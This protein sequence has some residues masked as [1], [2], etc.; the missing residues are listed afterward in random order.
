[1]LVDEIVRA[2]KRQVG[3]ETGSLI[4]TEDVF[5]WINEAQIQI[6][7]KTGDTTT[8]SPAIPVAVGDGRYSIP[9]DFLKVLH[10]ELDGRRLQFLAE[11]QLRT[12]YPTLETNAQQGVPKF[13]CIIDNGG[14]V[15]S[16]LLLA[17]V[18]GSTGN[19]ILT[20]LKRPPLIRQTADL[21]TVPDQYHSTILTF[22][23]GKARQMEGDD[24]SWA[25]HTAQFKQEV[26][27]DAHDART[28]D[29]ETYP[30]IRASDGDYYGGYV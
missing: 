4:E 27:E 19:L 24:E 10:L 2:V 23:I 14:T 17:P 26:T 7:R 30:F 6:C 9:A 18:P 3:D 13:F 28:K 15:Q 8:I 21:L 20:Y 5:R 22:C 1:M 16:E 25:A 12:M 11:A 29:E